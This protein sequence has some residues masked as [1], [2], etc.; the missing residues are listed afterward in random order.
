MPTKD[1]MVTQKFNVEFSQEAIN[2]LDK[3]KNKLG[4]SSR[5]DVL[6][7]SVLLLNFVV[8]QRDKGYEVAVVM[9]RKGD[10]APIIKQ[11]LELS[12]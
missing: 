4:K 9:E 10:A 11:L 2:I 5:A 1:K 7:L 12:I 3:L 6:R 8:E